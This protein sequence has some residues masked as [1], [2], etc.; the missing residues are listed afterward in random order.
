MFFNYSNL[1]TT[2][3]YFNLTIPVR[4]INCCG[5]DQT[6]Y[7]SSMRRLS[8]ITKILEISINKRTTIATLLKKLHNHKKTPT[9]KL[10][11]HN[12]TDKDHNV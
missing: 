11:S 8:I 5:L 3:F 6:L 2:Y 12:Q 7:T 9:P 4:F 10:N 1:F